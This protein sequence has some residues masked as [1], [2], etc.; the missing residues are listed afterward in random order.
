MRGGLPRV[1]STD[2]VTAGVCSPRPKSWNAARKSGTDVSNPVPSRDESGANVLFHQRLPTSD[3]DP[4]SLCHSR[5]RREQVQLPCPSRGNLPGSD[6]AC[7]PAQTV[8]QAG[9]PTQIDELLTGLAQ[10]A[11]W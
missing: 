9:T 7:R 3:P 5:R 4:A 6:E 1:S 11:E 10:H 2:L 8:L